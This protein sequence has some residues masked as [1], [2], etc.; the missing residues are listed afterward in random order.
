VFSYMSGMVHPYDTVA[1]A[2]AVAGLVAI[3]TMWAWR[4]R[5]GWDGRITL[6]AMILLTAIWSGVLLRRNTFGPSW[7]P[8][9]ITTVAVAAAVC[10]IAVGAHRLS[11]TAVVVGMLAAI[12]G[13]SVFSIAT[14]ATP[15]QGS[16][17]TAL[18]KGVMQLGNWTGDEG[19]NADLAGLLAATRTEWSAATNGSQ[20][21]AALE[22]S[23][24]TAV[25]AIGGWSG[26]PVPTLESFIDD[27]HAG[28]IAY[29]VEAGRGR[30]AELPD[31]G[32]VVYGRSR[33]AAHTREIADWVAN[34][35]QPTVI[36][37]STVYRLT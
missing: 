34:H 29:Y 20:S 6:A 28:K 33:S 2:P 17:P 4:E 27:V 22:V 13:P 21:A 26:D 14:A 7:V 18:K 35:Y 23:S 15:H 24:G 5:A 3:G 37:E 9:V 36:G 32:D 11:A 1:M 8:W 10:V 16:I 19:S 30:A 25:M 31:H 12:G